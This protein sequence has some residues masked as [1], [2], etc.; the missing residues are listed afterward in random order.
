MATSSSGNSV[1]SSSTKMHPVNSSCT[2]SSGIPI[3]DTK[4]DEIGNLIYWKDSRG[5]EAW[6]KYDEYNRRIIATELE[7]EKIRLKKLPDKVPTSR[8]KLMDL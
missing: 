3:T 2:S 6:Y 5:R 8:F 7:L 4:Y 1:S